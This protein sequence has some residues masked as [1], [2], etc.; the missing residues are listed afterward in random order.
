[1]LYY[2]CCN[3]EMLVL[4]CDLMLL[5]FQVEIKNR[6]LKAAQPCWCFDS[7]ITEFILWFL[8]ACS[9]F[10]LWIY[11]CCHI[12]FIN[13]IV[14]FVMLTLVTCSATFDVHCFYFYL[15]MK[16]FHSCCKVVYLHVKRLPHPHD[17]F[18]CNPELSLSL[19]LT[20]SLLLSPFWPFP[21]GLWAS[22]T[23]VVPKLPSSQWTASRSAWKGS[24]CSWRGQ[25][26]PTAPTSPS[27][28]QPPPSW[29]P[30]AAVAHREKQ[31]RHQPPC[32]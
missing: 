31:V 16:W 26:M 9:L 8:A 10:I 12:V 30:G 24:R 7:P 32:F 20:L 17:P 15:P 1:M 3:F 22:T 29:W 14:V 13:T 21:Q 5:P 19:H 18:F 11:C 28:S 4:I 23:Q 2:S 25:R 6:N 27:P